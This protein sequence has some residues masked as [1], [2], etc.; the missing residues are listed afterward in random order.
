MGATE[1]EIQGPDVDQV[2][3]LLETLNAKDALSAAMKTKLLKDLH[4]ALALA[5]AA[6]VERMKLDHAQKMIIHLEALE[7]LHLA[8]EGNDPDDL[9]PAIAA[10]KK[11]GVEKFEIERAEQAMLPQ[12]ERLRRTS[13]SS[14]ESMPPAVPP[15]R[16]NSRSSGVLRQPRCRMVTSA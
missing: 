9:A 10:A 3:A 12:H 6:G 5:Q 2:K 14:V 7:D 4:P 15:S 11:A 1:L 16:R 8:M 13:V